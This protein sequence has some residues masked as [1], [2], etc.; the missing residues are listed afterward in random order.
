M[1][2][3]FLKQSSSWKCLN[4]QS[5]AMHNRV[6]LSSFWLWRCQLYIRMRM[7]CCNI[8]CWELVG[9]VLQSDTHTYLTFFRK[10][11]SQLNPCKHVTQMSQQLVVNI[12]LPSLPNCCLYAPWLWHP[13]AFQVDC[14]RHLC[15]VDWWVPP[16]LAS[17]ESSSETWGN[18]T[19]SGM[20]VAILW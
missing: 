8:Q 10:Q 19:D 13:F 20:R 2:K 16:S 14:L 18:V 17:L 15:M 3:C 12:S 6:Q 4:I 11:S 1:I 5:F 9:G 7:F